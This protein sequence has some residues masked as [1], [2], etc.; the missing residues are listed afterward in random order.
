MVDPWLNI[1]G[2]N[3]DG[4]AGLSSTSRSALDR[5]EVVFG[6]ARHLELAEIG[7]RG[8]AWPLPFSV[9]PVL[10]LRGTPVVILASG[11]PFWFGAGGSIASHLSAD[12]WVSHPAPSTFA[13]AANHLGWRL[14]ETRCFGLHSAPYARL[15]GHLHKGLRLICLLRDG[16]AP[17]ELA[18]WLTKQGA[19]STRMH[20][21]ERLGGPRERV[22]QINAEGFDFAACQ[23]P[24]T[25]A[26][27]IAQNAGPPNSAGLPDE[28][29]AHDGQ[30]TKQPIRA[31]TLAALAPRDGALLWD[32]GAGSGSVSVEWC[33]KG[34]RAIAIEAKPDRAANI[35]ANIARFG[36]G[37]HLALL[38]AKL[39]A[40]HLPDLARPDAVFIGGGA[41]DALL[42]ALFAT[43]ALG[44][45]LVINGVTLETEML[46]ANWHSR[47]GGNLLR[48]ELATA[49]PLGTMRGWAPSRPVV[50]WSVVV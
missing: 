33:L 20:V 49:A 48:V 1:I 44:T 9:E 37:Q 11:D 50:Q 8:S 30:I 5:A 14:E 46:L 17:A 42:N 25:V 34:G 13:L 31:I 21:L 3:E 19:G 26:L 35:T 4:L 39:D 15:L 12:E 2:L 29:F 23:A 41:N 47:K 45:R 36:L 7:P 32:I 10:A 38:E 28:D 40:S 6:A 18:A 22:R 27:E 24:V 16:D 43:L